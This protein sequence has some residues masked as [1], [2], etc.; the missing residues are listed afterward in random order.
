MDAEVEDSTNQPTEAAE[1]GE[2]L[3]LEAIKNAHQLA[4]TLG[5][6]SPLPICEAP[7]LE[8]VPQQPSG[9]DRNTKSLTFV[10]L[11]LA[12]LLAGVQV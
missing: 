5:P 3:S 8:D 12:L 11:A 1:E 9:A 4:H 10:L 7:P 6:L 2:S